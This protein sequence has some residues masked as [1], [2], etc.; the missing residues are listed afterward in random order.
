MMARISMVAVAVFSMAF[1]LLGCGRDSE[2]SSPTRETAELATPLSPG[3]KDK[4]LGDWE[5]FYECESVGTGSTPDAMVI[6]PGSRELDVTITLHSTWINPPTV[7]GRLTDPNTV[8]VPEQMISGALGT[9]VIT[10]SDGTL[11]LEQS[12]LGITCEGTYESA[13]AD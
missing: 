5:G 3:D 7:E 13:A 12:G 4:F 10:Y 9:A 2:G 8:T 11:T 6:E 1:S